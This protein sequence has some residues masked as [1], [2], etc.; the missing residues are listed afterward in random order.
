[1]E[2]D[3]AVPTLTW[4][5]RVFLLGSKEDDPFDWLVGAIIRIVGPTLYTFFWKNPWLGST[6]LKLKLHGLFSNYI[7]SDGMVGEIGWVENKDLI[8]DLR[9]RRP[10]FLR[11]LHVFENLLSLLWGIIHSQ[12]RDKWNVKHARE[13]HFFV[14][15]TYHVH[16]SGSLS[17]SMAENMGG[18]L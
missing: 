5:K 15:F 14:I 16:F 13:I 1:M 9:W 2:K 18:K 11:E 10:F 7:Q 6:L 4:W 12:D 17:S 8:W 3:N